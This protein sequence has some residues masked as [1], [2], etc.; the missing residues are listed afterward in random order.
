MFRLTRT[1][2]CRRESAW[3]CKMRHSWV[4]LVSNI[5][6]LCKL[7]LT[8]GANRSNVIM[9]RALALRGTRLPRLSLPLLVPSSGRCDRRKWIQKRAHILGS[10]C[11]TCWFLIMDASKS[12]TLWT[13]H[14]STALHL[15]SLMCSRRD[16]MHLR[17][18]PQRER[19]PWEPIALPQ[20][21]VKNEVWRPTPREH[22]VAGQVNVDSRFHFCQN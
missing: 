5:I 21:S 9:L 18:G 14:R 17:N 6:G 11:C 13:W 10:T 7:I 19:L 16:V 15:F 4:G 3:A 2:S 8:K 22:V 1:I 12:R 20:R